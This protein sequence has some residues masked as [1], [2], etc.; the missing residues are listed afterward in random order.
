MSSANHRRATAAMNT[1]EIRNFLALGQTMIVA[2]HRTD[3][4]IHLAPMWFTMLDHRPV[5]WTYGHSQKALNL[6]RDSTVTVLVEDGQA[7]EELRG[8]QLTGKASI[9]D[10]PHEVLHIGTLIHGKYNPT[11]NAA[12]DEIPE[13]LRKQAQKR[14]AIIVNVDKTTSWD[15][16]KLG[17]TY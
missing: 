1:H 8:V 2:S 6:R 7:Y 3:G 14:I 10:D 13:T 4:T 11:S 16:R 5:M 12:V 15:H 9:I 17:G